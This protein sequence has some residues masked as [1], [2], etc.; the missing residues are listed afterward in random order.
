MIVDINKLAKPTLRFSNFHDPWKEMKLEDLLSEVVDNRGKT[1][2]TEKDGIPLIE[3]N[4]FSNKKIDYSKVNKFISEETFNTWFRKYLQDEDIL[5]CTVGATAKIAFYSQDIKAGVAQNIVGLRFKEENQHFMFYLLSVRKNVNKFKKIEMGAVQPSV[6][7]SQMVKINFNIP[8]KLE[9]DKIAKFFSLIDDMIENFNEQKTKLEKYQKAVFQE[10]FS[11]NISFHDNDESSIRKWEEK[12]LGEIFTRVKQKN[13]DCKNVL[14][15]SAVYGLISQKKFFN[16]SVS[17][18]DLSA[19]TLL[20]RCDFAYNKSYSSGYP[21]GA[22]KMLKYFDEGVVSPLYICFR[23]SS[24]N[25]LPEFYEHYFNSGLLN[26]QIAKIAQE[27]ARNH[28]LLNISVDDFL[29]QIT[30]PC[31]TTAEQ[32]KIT[33]FLNSIDLMIINKKKQIEIA[34]H[35]KKGL[36]QEMFV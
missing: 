32:E 19:Y 11:Q 26:K 30:L 24:S 16:K 34:E 18:K 21:M 29:N 20:H 3:V 1:P 28:G 31:P 6:K 8:S 9:Q 2:P 27:G 5:F 17:S 35:W 12:T 36:L 4:A 13:L 10:I 23:V 22:I 15:I 33:K 7:V 25:N 14:T